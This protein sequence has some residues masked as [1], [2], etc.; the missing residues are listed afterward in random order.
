[1]PAVL[2]KEG[3]VLDDVNST[4]ALDHEHA[5]YR[6]CMFLLAYG[7]AS[8]AD[9][10]RLAA[11]GRLGELRL[12]APPPL[13]DYLR[14]DNVPLALLASTS[15]IDARHYDC[16]L[17]G[18]SA[19]LPKLPELPFDQLSSARRGSTLAPSTNAC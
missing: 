15:H 1:M 18:I 3:F 17:P 12:A 8:E 10:R 16:C 13:T 19:A 2:H 7:A 4:L 14:F 11:A 6:T 5:L 9:Y